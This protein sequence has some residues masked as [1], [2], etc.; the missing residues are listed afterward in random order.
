MAD[1]INSIN[2]LPEYLRTD[3]NAKF[4]SATLDQWIQPA[5]L[6]RINGFIGSKN[7]PNYNSTSDVYIAETLGL[8]RDYQLTPSLVVNNALYEVQDVIS[9][10][11]LVNRITLN[12]GKT[13]NLDRLLRSKFYSYD[14]H[15]DWDKLINFQEYYWL[16]EGPDVIEVSEDITDIEQHI[17]GHKSYTLAR[18]G[19]ELTNGLKLRFINADSGRYYDKDYFVEGVGSDRGIRLINF[20]TLITPEPIASLFNDQYG[21]NDF[22]YYKFDN[23]QTL[24]LIPEYTT[25]NRASQDINS[26]SRYNRWV[27][28]EVIR[29]TAETKGQLPVYPAVYRAQRPII[30]FAADLKLYN[31]GT[32]GIPNI[33]FV[34]TVTK[35]P[36]VINGTTGYYIDQIL[37]QKGN[38]IIF[39]ASSDPSVIYQ[40]NY[41]KKTNTYSIAASDTAIVGS[42]V[43]VDLGVENHGTDWYFDG[44]IWQRSQSHTTL[45]QAPLFDLFDNTETS[46]GDKTN[47]PSNFEGCKVFGYTI[48]TGTPDKYLGF[49]LKYRN[50]VEQGD[51]LFSNYFMT[52]TI[53]VTEGQQHVTII[54]ASSAYLKFLD[55]YVN[56]W[57]DAVDY[58]IPI[59]QFQT[60]EASTSSISV[61]AIDSPTTDNFQY[62]VFLNTVKLP[63]TETSI[64]T[65]DGSCFINFNNTLAVNSNILIKIYTDS[66]A[67]DNGYYEPPLGLTNNP[68]N[69]PISQ[70]TLSELSDHVN[71]MVSR[72]SNFQGV[73]PGVNNL[74]DLPNIGQ[75]GTR[76]I[77]NANPIAFADMF[78]GKKEHNVIDAITVAADQY[79]QFKEQLIA[80]M[81]RVT[82]QQDPVGLLDEILSVIN[83]S[84]TPQSPYYMSDMLGYGTNK[85]I[86]TY[87][88]TSPHYI[89][90]EPIEYAISNPFS[91]T[92][93]SLRS[94]LVYLNGVQLVLYQDYKFVEGDSFVA[95]NVQML[96]G[97]VLTIVEY[98][99]TSGCYIPSTPSKLGLYPSF[100]PK[101]YI[102]S[103]YLYPQTVIRGHDGSVTIA[104]GDFRDDVILEFEKRVY[105]NIKAVYRSELFD[106]NSIMPGAF[107]TNQYSLSEVTDILE[108][109]FV[110]WAG[111]NGIDYIT[112]N[113]FNPQL[114]T[115]WNYLGGYI[116][117]LDL[118][119]SGYWRSIYKYL[120][121]TDRPDTCPWEMFGFVEQPDWWNSQYGAEYDLLWA[122]V[123]A[124]IIRQGP[125]AGVDPL[126]ARP[127]IVELGLIPVDREG[128][129]IDPA[130][131]VTNVTIYSRRQDWKFGDQAPAETA[132]R[133]SSYWP[134]AV[135][136]LIA[137]TKPVDYASIMYDLS[138]V[139]RNIAGQ[140]TYGDLNK[141]FNFAG[142]P[143]HGENTATTAE[144]FSY[145]GIPG[146]LISTNVTSGYS[147]W[148]SEVGTQRTQNY[149]TELRSDLSYSNFNLFYKVGGFVNKDKLQIIIDAYEP[150]SNSPGALLPRE[151]YTL[152]LNVGNP[153]ISAS[154]S[155][156]I[157]QK[158]S[159]GNFLIKGYD[160]Q[161][162]Y[163]TVYKPIRNSITPA[164]TVGGISENYMTWTAGT[165]PGGA[166]LSS[167]DT[168]TA[169][170]ATG[171]FYQAGMIVA[172]GG[173]YYR[174]KASHRSESVFNP[175]LYQLLPGLPTTGGATVQIAANFNQTPIEIPYGMEFENLQDVYDVIVGYGA[176]LKDQGFI[177]DEYN[178]NIND[179]VNWEF[180]GK[181]F[182][183][184]TTQN[185][186]NNNVI[187]LSPFA[188]RIKY[189][190]NQSVVDNLFDTFYEYSLL[191]ANGLPFPKSSLDIDRHGGVCTISSNT[192]TDGI[193]FARLNSVQKEHSLVF[194]NTTIFN[195]VIYDIET[196]YQQER[197]KISGFRTK[198]WT[199][200]LS[201]PGFVYDD[202]QITD[203]RRNT[204]YQSA[205]VV[206][207]N[208]TYYSAKSNIEPA[209]TFD[210][211]NW[212]ILDSKPDGGLL[213]N[214]DYK[215]SQFQDFYSL[216]IDNFDAGQEKMAQHLTGYTPRVYLNNIFTDPIAQYKFYQ[217]FIKEK[218]T[219][220]AVQKLSKATVQNL[221]GNID[222]T[223]EWA[224]RIGE[225][226]SFST[227]KE[228]ENTLVEGTFFENPQIIQFVNKKP[229]INNLIYYSTASNWAILPDDYDPEQTF[230]T[231]TGTYMDNAYVLPTAG[232]V[233][234]DD[235]TAT[236]FDQYDLVSNISTMS[237]MD[238]DTVWV[239][240]NQDGSWDVLR[241]RLVDGVTVIGAELDNYNQA[242]V[243]TTD[244]PHRLK[245]GDIVTVARY[246]NQLDGTYVV[247]SIDNPDK[248]SVA[249]AL[250]AIE[251]LSIPVSGQLFKFITA[252]AN[253]FDTLPD[254]VDLLQSPTG[255]MYWVDS[256]LEDRSGKW[257]VYNK[258]QNYYPI[259]VTSGIKAY[260]EWLGYSISRVGKDSL[261][262]VGSPSCPNSLTNDYGYGK[263][264]VYVKVDGT[265]VPRLRYFLNQDENRPYYNRRL[266]TATNFGAAVA[267]DDS[268]FPGTQAGLMFVGAPKTS[269]VK[270]V[271][272][273]HFVNTASINGTS[274]NLVEQGLVTISSIDPISNE[275]VREITLASPYPQNYEQFGSKLY[276][277][278]NTSSKLLL[279][280]AP[281]QIASA[282]TV[283][284]YKVGSIT[285][286]TTTTLTVNYIS[287]LTTVAS[288]P[289]IKWG[290]S[291]SG[292]DDGSVIAI[293][294]PGY[295]DRTGLVHIFNGTNTTQ[296]IH[297]PFSAGG[298]FGSKVEVSSDGSYLIVS[299]PDD[300]S[301]SGN[302]KSYGRIAI[303]QN[304][305]G[306]FNTTSTVQ[307]LDNPLVDSEMRF[308]HDISINTLTNV[309]AVSALGTD[310]IGTNFDDPQT[311]NIGGKTIVTI[312]NTVEDQGTTDFYT[313]V[314]RT[315]TVYVYNKL[316]NRFVLS[317]ELA[318]QNRLEGVDHGYA[319][320]ISS[321]NTI[322]VG[323]PAIHNQSTGSFFYQYYSTSTTAFSWNAHREQEALV[324]IDTIQRAV[325]IDTFTEEVVDYLESI[326]PA[327]GKISGLADQEI[328]YK[329]M[330]DPAIYSVGS[331]GTVIS[332]NNNW[333]DNHIGDVW[334]DLSTVKYQWYEQGDLEYRKNNWGSVFP[335]SSID[336]YEWVGSALL[337]SEWSVQADT[338]AGLTNGISGQ[339]KFVDDSTVSIK[340]T[341][342]SITDSFRN[343]YYYWVKN[344]VI[345]PD[346]SSRKLSVS[347]ISN[348]ISDPTGNGIQ[349]VA[350]ISSNAIILSNIGSMPVGKRINLNI[351]M[352][353]NPDNI[354][355]H[356]E[357][358]LLQENS[359]TSMPNA[360]LE[361]KLV[362]SLVGH[363]SQGNLIPD[364]A[365]SPR[366]AYGVSIRPKQGLFK[367]RFQALRN[368]IDFS[369]NILISVPLT[370]NYNFVNLNSAEPIPDVYKNEWDQIVETL[371]DRDAIDVHALTPI[372]AASLVATVYDGK[373]ISVNI[374]NPG[375][376]YLIAPTVT[377]IG[378]ATATAEI[379]TEINDLGQIKA[380]TIV[381]AGSG[382][383]AAPELTVRPYT[384]VVVNDS[385]A[386]NRWA[387]HVWDVYNNRWA[388]VHTQ[389]YNTPL[390]WNYVDYST[391][392]YDP[393][394]IIDYT[395]DSIYELNTLTS[396]QAG[397]YIKIKN[398]GDGRSAIITP[399]TS[400]YGSFSS[401]YDLVWSQNGTIQLSNDLWDIPDSQLGFDEYNNYDTTL[402][403]Q[404][405]DKE[406]KYI[407]SALKNDIFINDL[408]VNWNQF[409]FT[410]VKYCLY[411]QKLLDWAF[412]TTFINVTNYAGE[413]DQRPVYKI[414]TSSYFEQYI[415][416]VKPYHTQIRN[417]ITNQTTLDSIST[418]NTDF[419]LPAYYNPTDNCFET[420][421]V[422]ST[423]TNF[424]PWSDWAN[425]YSY[426][427]G[428]IVINNPGTLY[429]SAPVVQISS[430]DLSN[431]TT[432]TAQAYISGKNIYSVLVTN[433]GSGY[434]STPSV[435]L[436]GGT[437]GTTATVYAKL[438][439]NLIRKN[440]IDI[441]FDRISTINQIG[442][443]DTTDVFYCDGSKNEFVLSWVAQADKQTIDVTLDNDL[444]LIS[445]Y[446]IKFYTDTYNGYNKK[447]SKLVFLNYVPKRDQIV[448]IKYKK[449]AEL[450]SAVERIDYFTSIT[451][452]TTVTSGLSYSGMT[453][454]GA[455]FDHTSDWSEPYPAYDEF[456]WDDAV[457]NYTAVDTIASSDSDKKN[458]Y[459]Q[460]ESVENINLYQ[461]ANVIS[462]TDRMFN[463]AT[464]VVINIDTSTNTVTL[465]SPVVPGYSIS[466]GSTIE[467]WNND[468]NF[469]ILD[470][471]TSA[472]SW[473]TSTSSALMTFLGIEPDDFELNTS[474]GLYLLGG[475]INSNNLFVDGD[476]FYTEITGFTP[477]E[478]VS[479]QSSDS[480]GINVY[481]RNRI[482]SPTVAVSYIDIPAYTTSTITLTVAPPNA[483]SI[484]VVVNYANT[485]DDVVF[486]Y[487]TSTDWTTSTQFTI[488]W[489][490]K[491]LILPPQ[492]SAALVGYTTILTAGIGL[493]DHIQAVTTSSQ[494]QLRSVGYYKN[495]FQSYYVTVDGQSITTS[496]STSTTYFTIGNVNPLNNRMALDFYN[497]STGSHRI[498]AWLF[499]SPANQFNEV[500]SQ[501]FVYDG[502]SSTFTMLYPPKG[503][504]PA[505]AGMIVEYSNGTNTKRLRPPDIAYYE[506][507]NTV[508]S[509]SSNITSVT[510]PIPVNNGGYSPQNFNDTTIRVFRNEYELAYGYDFTIDNQE[511]TITIIPRVL[512]TGDTIAI[513]SYARNDTLNYDFTVY[514]NK[515]TITD[516]ENLPATILTPGDTIKVITFGNQDTM[517]M[518]TENFDCAGSGLYQISRPAINSNYV[519][520]SIDGEWL[521][522]RIDFTVLDDQRSIQLADRFT[523]D[524]VRTVTITSI[525]TDNG[526]ILGYRIFTDMF[527][528]TQFK[529]LSKQNTTYLTQPLYVY[530]TEIYVNDASVLSRPLVSKRIPGVV[531]IDGERIEYYRL[532]GNVLSQL[533]RG[534]LGTAPKEYS[535]IYTK[536]ID[537]GVVQ[538][539][540]YRE[541][542]SKQSY[543]NIGTT[544]TYRINTISTMTYYDT[545][546]VE[547][548]SGTGATI[549]SDTP[550][551]NLIDVAYQ[552]NYGT[553]PV[554]D[555]AFEVGLM[556]S[557]STY[558]YLP[559]QPN[560]NSYVVQAWFIGQGDPGTPVPH[561]FRNDGIS[562]F[563]DTIVAT[564]STHHINGSLL[565]TTSTFGL[566]S[567]PIDV[568]HITVEYTTGT[569][570]W[571]E[572]TQYPVTHHAITS[573]TTSSSVFSVGRNIKVTN[574]NTVVL[575]NGIKLAPYYDYLISNTGTTSTITIIPHVMLPGDNIDIFYFTA[576]SI[577]SVIPDFVRALAEPDASFYNDENF[578]YRIQGNTATIGVISATS[579]VSTLTYI[580]GTSWSTSTDATEYNIDSNNNLVI[581]PQS[582]IGSL[583]TT[584]EYYGTYVDPSDQVSVYYGGRP[585]RKNGLIQ[586]DI[587]VSYDSPPIASTIDT[588][589]T[590]ADLPLT[591]VLNTAYIASDTNKVWVYTA[592]SDL[593]SVNG[594]EYRGLN[595][596]PPEFTIDPLTQELTLNIPEALKSHLPVRIDVVKKD[597]AAITEWNN[598]DPMNIGNTLSLVDSTTPQAEFLQARPAEL[599]DA[600]YYGG[601]RDLTDKS[602]FALT[603]PDGNPLQEK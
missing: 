357:W 341:Y 429:T 408:K 29:I 169:Q 52:D 425:N 9:L 573:A 565:N 377:V 371:E 287:S 264:T 396:V 477:E 83:Q 478:L 244:N 226:G 444:V 366:Q 46:Y 151:D 224:F 469:N 410:A 24:P 465:N 121:D 546:I 462:T 106:I 323:A 480:L 18:Y 563:S 122:D 156:M 505:E 190:Y 484:S 297:S 27:H 170:T 447:Y 88:I 70:F 230:Y 525:A 566:S 385:G 450:M 20:D 36:T 448:R 456:Y 97:D 133:R 351:A 267:Y 93:L 538:T 574:T 575:R 47:L 240:F 220:N 105:N 534:T 214:F 421:G 155:G 181:E 522:N 485:V 598:L 237:L 497:L 427:V 374:D 228:L 569:Y 94:L 398:I 602:G 328:K 379:A 137:L 303:Y 23:T 198:D 234:L 41:N 601:D 256:D 593:D 352:D 62:E 14:P 317:E 492:S 111:Q 461:Y 298:G 49:P 119:V 51:Y 270:M 261:F 131:I 268:I 304:E 147:V 313:K 336:V 142:L 87:T 372:T 221:Q 367:N 26:W 145:A 193:Y 397:Q 332:K 588:V 504:G 438:V 556:P 223:E 275:E 508:T 521:I 263:V 347:G 319:V 306:L 12:G 127:G 321:D 242:I 175:A 361:K 520:V 578:T 314:N 229:N 342:D 369:N 54:P 178:S 309:L 403:N 501:T 353:L 72:L 115:T 183:Y 176:W 544:N 149:T 322:F 596:L 44:S 524:L 435:N 550:W 201:S 173:S 112:N 419:D 114:S 390:Y 204:P 333:I 222:F 254:D 45:N 416:E 158:A 315:G 96:V 603:L 278:L 471:A 496:T 488:D 125:R 439:N 126:Y 426:G 364:P 382:Y 476:G 99:D 318:P 526:P 445:D 132:W 499:D 1:N 79:N 464:V 299:A 171:L 301:Y 21:S 331:T 2:F 123:Q 490:S 394:K 414:S 552:V 337:P 402:Y 179:V 506:F 413:L 272:G 327:K 232:Y 89:D 216:D 300:Y 74:R 77:S 519:W 207:Y 376:G 437:T 388:R 457:S 389:S 283:Y 271:N 210:I 67:N 567:I 39:N 404:A 305:D 430:P 399:T 209:L 280:G 460:V 277:Q 481:T 407:L 202:V 187:T 208:G 194:K 502:T 205:S 554:E 530:D 541:N 247:E 452:Y 350:P 513:M 340:Q 393:F 451:D 581:P 434:T 78:I 482:T 249:T 580:A 13:D 239:G 346:L 540:P 157:I 140:W 15:I 527:D 516:P 225:Y 22:D 61:L 134:F 549:H 281:G 539:I 165:V 381:N 590:V 470:I 19:V 243:F 219:R 362:D 269:Y 16:V 76:L 245:I 75:Y 422:D 500:R 446:T 558:I 537:Q 491:S 66:S 197:M 400:D 551:N 591:K 182:L 557:G 227:Y 143:I 307:I 406:L 5:Q 167:V 4:L 135:Q 294:A 559:P 570:T 120:Y 109:Y 338:T 498:E 415:E 509:T 124:G 273:L 217:G 191:L 250:T 259:D 358:L 594:Y 130:T 583:K 257:T 417:F 104:Y 585:L 166:S 359:M 454:Q 472:T 433:T 579:Y 43:T 420:V 296:V 543:I 164:I 533:R 192:S 246:T 233:R 285:A 248:F 475:T 532:N 144:I 265:P 409:F 101:K 56:V 523:G 564:T 206:Q 172:H 188:D 11:D 253:T 531:I 443:I 368:L 489:G 110:K 312:V 60:I 330:F 560:D 284:A 34:D 159:D 479:G 6:E 255:T 511:R 138:Q 562:L 411:E 286:G 432:A 326:D 572:N 586:Q 467:F 486:E 73:F 483:D 380:V 576:T 118:H 325:L 50:S 386:G 252:R 395:I 162:P 185:W 428:E 584:I 515:L 289:G 517:L 295:N 199:G 117:Q 68:L 163:F 59:L 152:R 69:G 32:I 349:F 536:V 153:I 260:N 98:S 241:Y 7:T 424:H 235:V 81:N 258:T 401:V 348:I 168:T 512:F 64:S 113:V 116:P 555:L 42:Q 80:Q 440:T 17:L 65:S 535:Q 436:I 276:V 290:H 154:I 55:R 189:S 487:T 136:R 57:T 474:T 293:G 238:G 582:H 251:T 589:D 529:R 236:A 8:R 542:I 334:W 442:N 320:K 355:R 174:V 468:T 141:F 324:D 63:A 107:R 90:Q 528:R 423:L 316:H 459:V 431:G 85:K 31:H 453:L 405:P 129:L 212:I 25:I 82:D 595:Y 458:T 518:E 128:N 308:G 203:W 449:S 291:I 412:K 356:T 146:S 493:V 597:Y 48:G 548:S 507:I 279:I 177:F 310:Y 266:S 592:S 33:D 35:D 345:V 510:Y 40:V 568:D 311:R 108:K 360:L 392:A 599:P 343:Y 211:T 553:V 86:T 103:S 195:D 53:S 200:D 37:L 600:Y 71:T 329:S 231:T 335:G 302:N 10:D 91:T 288:T 148:V 473:S 184:W 587:T 274:T 391:S 139:S 282:G 38:R 150:N 494:L 215:I 441:K 547:L 161:N 561:L 344:K 292:S 180:S 186:A 3:K 373:I 365:L 102:D 218:G 503:N 383:Y 160:T 354:P 58:Q 100:Q 84:R 514:K 262:A 495:L 384:V 196:G 30:E 339:P 577:P 463:T 28:A 455:M 95:I 387:K 378:N 571:V 418:Y 370:G 375:Y 92:E 213:P 545:K 466:S 363:D